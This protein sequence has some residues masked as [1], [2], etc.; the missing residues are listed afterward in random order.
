VKK[1]EEEEEGKDIGTN[2]KAKSNRV[3]WHMLGPQVSYISK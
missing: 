3:D 2:C 1:E